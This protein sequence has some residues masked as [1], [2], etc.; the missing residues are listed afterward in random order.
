MKKMLPVRFEETEI[1]EIR[2]QA[3]AEGRSLQDYVHDVLMLAIAA[4][5]QRRREALDH[6]L[7]VSEGLNRRLAQ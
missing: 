7:R 2:A 5:T 1:E 4:R 3:A 6:V